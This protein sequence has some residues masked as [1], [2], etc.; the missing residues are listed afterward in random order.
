VFHI[1][2]YDLAQVGDLLLQITYSGMEK[3]LQQERVKGASFV[4]EPLLARKG[5]LTVEAIELGRV[6]NQM[7]AQLDDQKLVLEQKASKRRGRD[8]TF[9]NADKKGFE[10]SGFRV[11]Q[12]TTRGLPCFPL[13]DGTPVKERKK[14]AILVDQD[15][16]GKKL[17]DNGLVKTMRFGYHTSNSFA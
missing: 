14:G 10:V 16:L 4:A 8:Q 17:S 15:V 13:R 5:L 9:S 7:K 6:G 3:S 11:S 2:G 1:E 12:A